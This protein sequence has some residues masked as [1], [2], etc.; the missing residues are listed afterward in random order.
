M[1]RRLKLHSSFCSSIIAPT[2]LVID[3]WLGKMPATLCAA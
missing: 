2:S 1:Q 3:A